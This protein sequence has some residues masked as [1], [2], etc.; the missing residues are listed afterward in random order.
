MLQ[1]NCRPRK[2]DSCVWLIDMKD[3]YEY[4][5]IYVDDLLR[6][7]EG[8]QKITQDFT[9]KFQLKIKGDGPLEYHLG[10]DCILDKD[11]TLVAQPTRYINKILESYEN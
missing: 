5:S 3:A 4:I 2:A 8:P 9:G 11:S 1:L 6:A 10:S 7:S